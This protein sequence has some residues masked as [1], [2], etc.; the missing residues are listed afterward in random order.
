MQVLSKGVG[1][2]PVE[3]KNDGN[4]C[5]EFQ[6]RKGKPA[7]FIANNCAAICPVVCRLPC[8]LMMCLAFSMP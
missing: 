5:I 1:S 3:W 6:R 8:E 7:R 2:A 4:N